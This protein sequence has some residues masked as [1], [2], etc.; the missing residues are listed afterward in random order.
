M[1]DF[2]QWSW[3]FLEALGL[4]AFFDPDK[5]IYY[6]YL[7]SALVMAIGYYCFLKRTKSQKTVPKLLRYL[8]PKSVWLHQSALVD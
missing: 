1:K 2:Q 4:T 3:T 8:F 6:P 5:R 7:L